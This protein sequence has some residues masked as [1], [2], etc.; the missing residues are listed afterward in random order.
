MKSPVA[1]L[2]CGSAL[3]LAAALLLA[4]ALILSLGGPVPKL[5][6]HIE[7]GSYATRW[8]N[9]IEQSIWPDEL[10]PI[11]ASGTC[12]PGVKPGPLQGERKAKNGAPDIVFITLDAVRWDHT[13]PAGYK[14]DTTPNLKRW[15][16]RA[17][18]LPAGDGGSMRGD[19]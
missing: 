13:S 1:A 17:A 14:R 8:V 15:A 9:A 12:K 19:R 2:L 7:R 18:V 3:L 5:A 10:T 11:K 16:G 4:L 6:L